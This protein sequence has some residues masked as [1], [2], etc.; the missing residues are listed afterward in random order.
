MNLLL[1]I[2]YDSLD[3]RSARRNTTTY[4]RQHKTEKRGHTSMP[5]ARF[6]PTIPVLFERLETV[7]ALAR[8]LG[9]ALIWYETL[10]DSIF[11]RIAQRTINM[12][13]VWNINFIKV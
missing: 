12:Y 4:T 5:R 11:F 10:E 7:R 1:D 2:R 6:E 9:P 13:L 3:G 8:P